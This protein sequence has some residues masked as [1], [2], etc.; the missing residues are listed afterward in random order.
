MSTF[1]DGYDNFVHLN[2]IQLG[3]DAGAVYVGKIED[4]IEKLAK[5]LNEQR[6]K[7][8]NVSIN[9]AKG[10]VA[11]WWHEGAFNIDAAVKGVKTRAEAPDDNGLVDI[12]LTSGG[13]YQVKYYK[14]GDR[15]AK[16]QAKINYERYKE[17]CAKYRK[18][19]NGQNPPVTAEEY[20]KEKF[21]NDPYYLG[22][23]RL[24][25]TDQMK[26]AKAWLERKIV[27]ETNGGRPEQVKRYRDTLDK[28]TDRIKSS[29]GAESIPLTEEEARELAKLA[30]EG[31]F[32][33]AEW[34]LTTEE[35]V[36]FEYI[37]NQAFKAGLSAA[38]VSVVLKIA[39]E[40]CGIICK[41]IK[42][43]KINAEQ[44]KHLGFAAIS[45]GAEGF[46]RGTV[47]AAVTT[48]C[49]AGLMGETLKMLNPSIIGAIT[50]IA[51]NTIQ[52]ACL[53]AIGKIRKHDFAYKCAEDLVITVCS[54]GVGMAG[55]AVATAWFT[56]AATVFG[57]MIGSFVGSVVGS[58]MYK[59]IYSCV[60]SF[61][62]ES[63]S[64]FF[65]LVDQ[66]Y[67]LP[68][69]IIEK[70]GVKVFEYEKFEPVK[71]THQSFQPQHF[72]YRQYEP[73]RVDIT[74]LRRG[75]IGVGAI[76]YAR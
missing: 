43:G 6:R 71:F 72:R 45:G 21:P 3:A 50:A 33:P 53:L 26:D 10:F 32:D 52:N 11:E 18:E 66:C 25:P 20:L 39:P 74:F 56:P 73:I 48:V 14:S 29:D 5:A 41:L 59:G 23:G 15:S 7:I 67:E 2:S 51:M 68:K 34:G 30:K 16:Q 40:V 19:H 44:F 61:C 28:L 49:K 54:V 76:G 58:F 24:I 12:V 27:E 65:G 75:V 55:A 4:E 35:L 13:K 22:Q 46:V 42:D 70:I 8:D 31:G 60:I 62:I 47:A 38:L 69:D 37:M 17:Y 63:G 64:T 1:K 9:Y 36:E 57:Y